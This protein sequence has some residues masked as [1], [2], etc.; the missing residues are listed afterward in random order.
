MHLGR[1]TAAS[2][3]RKS[4]PTH[5]LLPGLIGLTV[6]SIACARPAQSARQPGPRFRSAPLW[7][8]AGCSPACTTGVLARVAGPWGGPG[9][10]KDGGAGETFG[11]PRGEGDGCPDGFPR[12]GPAGTPEPFP[13]TLSGSP[14][15]GRV[16]GNGGGRPPKVVFPGQQGNRYHRGAHSGRTPRA[17]GVQP[18]CGPC[19]VLVDSRTVICCV[20]RVTGHRCRYQ[21]GGGFWEL[22]ARR[23]SVPVLLKL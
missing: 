22:I 7:F 18:L 15:G 4:N 16:V 5:Y 14:W 21:F 13:T 11:E 17:A 19:A 23:R 3:D 10:A 12:A 8:R 6:F 20:R 1:P 9:G 2:Q